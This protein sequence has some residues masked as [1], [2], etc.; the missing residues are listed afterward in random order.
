MADEKQLID[1]IQL[2]SYFAIQLDESIDTT[3][4]AMLLVYVRFEDD[5]DIVE[6]CL[7]VWNSH[8]RRL[9]LKFSGSSITTS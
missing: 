3:N 6:T 7:V 1:K 8:S 2:S 9:V 5:G 4:M